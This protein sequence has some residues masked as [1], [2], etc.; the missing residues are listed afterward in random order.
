[1]VAHAGTFGILIPPSITMIL[2]GVATETSIGRC[3][4]AGVIP[5]I[6][7]VILSSIWIVISFSSSARRAFHHA[8]EAMPRQATAARQGFLHKEKLEALSKLHLVLIIRSRLSHGG[9]PMRRSKRSLCS[10]SCIIEFISGEVDKMLTHA[11]DDRQ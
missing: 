7:L 2:Y 5:G 4:I 11:L 8:S 6:L 9:P 10:W 3:F 1:M